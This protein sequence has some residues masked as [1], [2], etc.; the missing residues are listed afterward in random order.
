MSCPQLADDVAAA[1]LAGGDVLLLAT[2]TICGLHARAD[3]AA[4][5]ERVLALKGRHPGQ[6]FLLLA[7]SPE[8]ALS[9]CGPVTARVRSLCAAAWPGPFTFI[10]PAGAGLHELV[11]D[12]ARGTV[13]VRVP[14]REDLRQL[15]GRAGGPLASTSANRTGEPPLVDLAAAV[16]AFGNLVDGWWGGSGG[17]GEPAPGA[18]S[19]LVDLTADPP[20]VLRSGPRPLP[21]PA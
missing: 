6:P 13:A 14:G 1:R 4:A 10:L 8:Q 18:P 16:A 17:P 5:L 2:D 21:G 7:G 15:I 11:R 20:R 9:L 19:A 12:V 3:Q